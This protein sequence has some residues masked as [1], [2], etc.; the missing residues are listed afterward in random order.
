MLLQQVSAARQDRQA[1]YLLEN[2]FSTK[3]RVDGKKILGAASADRFFQNLTSL[4]PQDQVAFL[5]QTLRE[6]AMMRESR[7]EFRV[8]WEIGNMD[9]LNTLMQRSRIDNAALQ[10][11]L[12]EQPVKEWAATIQNLQRQAPGQTILVVVPLNLMS[13]P[14]SLPQQM[15]H[16][17]PEIRQITAQNL[18]DG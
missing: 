3:G 6:I 14:Q 8:N 15:R 1:R 10:H 2:Y 5:R 12:Q 9:A 17:H 4:S 7:D 16:T 11:I 13:G 18:M